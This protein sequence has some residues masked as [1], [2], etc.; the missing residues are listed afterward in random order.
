MDWAQILVI[1]LAIFLALF[2]LLGIVLVAM[3]IRVTKQIRSITAS[4][5]HTV[6]TIERA[7][8]GVKKIANPVLLF[9][10]IKKI[11]RQKKRGH[12]DTE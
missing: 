2:L 5:Q 3:L 9:A 6:L 10:G 1:I 7:V 11:I 8:V 4:A 12:D